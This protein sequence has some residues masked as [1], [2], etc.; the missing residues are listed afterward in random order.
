MKGKRGKKV[1][2]GKIERK[3]H[4]SLEVE[5]CFKNKSQN[6]DSLFL[7]S[8]TFFV[9][10]SLRNCSARIDAALER[11]GLQDLGKAFPLM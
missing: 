4:R 9:S 10:P 3:I 8:Y 2:E 1:S 7:V 6:A 5:A 11:I